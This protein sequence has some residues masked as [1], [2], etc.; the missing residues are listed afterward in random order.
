MSGIAVIT[1]L[2]LTGCSQSK[3]IKDM[4]PLR[5][6]VAA[7]YQQDNVEVGVFN[8]NILVVVLDNSPFIDL[9]ESERHQKEKELAKFARDHYDSIDKIDKINIG[10]VSENNYLILRYT[11]KINESFSKS[12][13]DS[14]IPGKKNRS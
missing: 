2:L 9:P 10:L 6:A 5:K 3:A 13:L 14:R 7:S 8:G 1:A 11:R 4:K 12:E